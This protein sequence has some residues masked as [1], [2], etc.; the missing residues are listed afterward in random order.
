M[1]WVTR[2]LSFAQQLLSLPLLTEPYSG[3]GWYDTM[4]PIFTCN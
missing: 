4:R 2:E 1:V 3:A